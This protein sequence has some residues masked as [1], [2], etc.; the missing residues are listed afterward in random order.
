MQDG[1]PELAIFSPYDDLKTINEP[2]RAVSANDAP[3]KRSK[4][5][6]IKEELTGSS[7]EDKSNSLCKM[8]SK[9][10]VEDLFLRMP[11]IMKKYN[12]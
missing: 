2:P 8:Q 5:P 6:K 10:Y 9:Q 12:Y 7:F 1:F 4:I 11:K 3:K